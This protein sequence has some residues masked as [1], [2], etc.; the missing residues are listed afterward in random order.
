VTTLDPTSIAS[1]SP[2][3]PTPLAP[4]IPVS[5]WRERFVFSGTGSE[6]F[7]I[8][9]VNILLTVV[10]LGIYSAW[11][12]VRRTQYFYRNTRLAGASF[13]YHGD[14]LA[15]LKGRI[16][17]A[18]LFGSY[19]AAGAVSPVAGAVAFLVLIAAMPW[20]IARS[21]RF[22]FY[23][24]S[25]RGLRFRFSGSTGDAYK[26]FLAYPVLAV[27]SLMT[28]GPLWHHRLKQYVHGNAAFGRTT[29]T[30]D[31]TVSSF[32][33]VYLAAAGLLLGFIAAAAA[34]A[35]PFLMAVGVGESRGV[36][37]VAFGISII[38]AYLLGS[39]SMWAFTTARVQ[40]LAWNHT[41]LGP[42]R[43]ES[44]IE[45]RQLIFITVTNLLGIVFTLGMYK[46][47][48]EV[49]LTQYLLGACTV[50]V[51]GNLNEFVAGEAL[52][53]GATGEEAMEMFD[54]DLAI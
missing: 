37:A 36:A 21:L 26:T 3:I 15:I 40:N 39:I 45:A 27:L 29:F 24:T 34:L 33:R 54:I 28:L 38:A 22:R 52:Q 25:Y 9:L 8:W 49:R 51:S 35:F 44:R 18:L 31:A 20:L 32:Y 43:F 12:K 53:I 7:R 23:N 30:F 6:Y 41:Q 14:P 42:H 17:A 13:D 46:P 11:A 10:T 5:T 16:I 4:P 1:D 50:V 2:V 19:Y 47:F 48:A